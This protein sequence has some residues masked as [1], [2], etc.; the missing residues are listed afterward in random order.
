[1]NEE[2][3]KQKDKEARTGGLAVG[4]VGGWLG[5]WL[6]QKFKKKGEKN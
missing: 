1:M 2:E 4:G 5:A 6:G 3:Q